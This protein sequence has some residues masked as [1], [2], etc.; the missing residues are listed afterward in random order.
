MMRTG[1]AAKLFGVSPETIK[2]WIDHTFL[3]EFFSETAKED[4]SNKAKQRH[5][6]DSDLLVLNTIR[7]EREKYPD[8]A[9]L[10]QSIA[11]VLRS[12]TR[13][14]EFPLEAANVD[15]GLT[16][17]NHLRQTL[18]TTFQRD[19]AF[20]IIAE[21]DREIARLNDKIIEVEAN[22]SAEKEK[23]LREMAALES[24]KSR[25]IGALE[26]ELHLYQSGRLT[27]PRSVE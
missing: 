1:K 23:L 12:G 4:A 5:L 3:C 2:N 11:D 24:E 10:W 7:V 27:A 15:T 19:N 14:L 26:N 17:A 18:T 8:T 13:H 22:A 20:S 6:T 25:I 21:K 9:V 16:A